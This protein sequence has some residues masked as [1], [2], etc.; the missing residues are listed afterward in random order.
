MPQNF[1]ARTALNPNGGGVGFLNLDADGRLLVSTETSVA[2]GTVAAFSANEADAVAVAILPAV[3]G[4]TNSLSGFMLSG[5][6]ATAAGTVVATITG[7]QGGTLSVPVAVPAGVDAQV[8][9]ITVN[10]TQPIPASAAD[11]A[12]EISLPALGAGSTNAAVA[13]W[14]TV[15]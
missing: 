13:I 2:S 9:P 1:A 7:L 5:T 10:L 11:T 14:G 12:I 4:K 15:G 8:G 3:A 6:G